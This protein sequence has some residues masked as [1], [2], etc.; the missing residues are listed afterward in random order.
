[1]ILKYIYKNYLLAEPL[2]NTSITSSKHVT[3]SFVKSGTL[4][5]PS[6]SWRISKLSV[7]DEF[8]GIKRSFTY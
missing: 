6:E 8:G 5:L 4:T 7:D 2:A 1:M 3:F